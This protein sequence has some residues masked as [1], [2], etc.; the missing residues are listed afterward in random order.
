MIEVIREKYNNFIRH[1][2]FLRRAYQFRSKR[3]QKTGK[4]G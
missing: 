2:R 3:G 4:M 1:F